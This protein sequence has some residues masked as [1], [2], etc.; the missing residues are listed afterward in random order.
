MDNNSSDEYPGCYISAIQANRP[1]AIPLRYEFEPQQ[2]T[3]FAR[4]HGIEVA[5]SPLVG[6]LDDDTLP[7]INWIRSAYLFG[8][9]HPDVGV[10]GS[11]IRGKFAIAPPPNFERIA[12]FLAL[13]ER[14]A[15]PHSI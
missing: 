12:A 2:G 15:T 10:F 1:A 3:G 14:G 5:N 13:T 8:Q 6:Y 4:Q 11:R 7:W 9:Q